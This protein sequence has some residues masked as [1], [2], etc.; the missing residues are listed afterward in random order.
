[1][2]EICHDFETFISYVNTVISSLILVRRRE[3]VFVSSAFLNCKHRRTYNIK[4]ELRRN[5]MWNCG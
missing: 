4:M 2:S 1:M 3:R 5:R